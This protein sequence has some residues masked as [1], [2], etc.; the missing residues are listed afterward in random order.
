LL[1]PQ[2]LCNTYCSDSSRL[3]PQHPHLLF[4][5]ERQAAHAARRPPPSSSLVH[6]PLPLI[7]SGSHSVI[8][9]L[10]C[11]WPFTRPESCLLIRTHSSTRLCICAHTDGLCYSVPDRI[12]DRRLFGEYNG[13]FIKTH[14][15]TRSHTY[16]HITQHYY[17]IIDLLLLHNCSPCITCLSRV[18]SLFSPGCN[19]S[20]SY[21]LSK[22]A[23][24]FSDCMSVSPSESR[25]V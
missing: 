16:L 3:L 7:P 9:V 2:R 22:M 4:A 13:I 15:R 25:L 8:F 6:L 10:H 24:L 23:L 18:Y 20:V 1:P 19:P 14:T 12:D 17:F 21:L 11:H 5:G